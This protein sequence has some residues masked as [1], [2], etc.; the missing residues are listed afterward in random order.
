MI[1]S[2][3]KSPKKM[4]DC[5]I[6]STKC[7]SSISVKID[8]TK[9]EK[10]HRILSN[11]ENY[12]SKDVQHSEGG[13]GTFTNGIKACQK[14]IQISRIKRRSKSDLLKKYIN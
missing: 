12:T 7:N 14:N 13:K 6:Y 1:Q 3:I 9:K 8:L 5:T 4:E 2:T 11:E 10:P